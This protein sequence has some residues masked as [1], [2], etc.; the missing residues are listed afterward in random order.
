MTF[1]R[2]ARGTLQGEAT[3]ASRG[4]KVL[5]NGAVV[6]AE[7][8]ATFPQTLRNANFSLTGPPRLRKLGERIWIE[9]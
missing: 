5:R 2:I 9:D 8:T 3:A 4:T 1:H 7:E 6:C